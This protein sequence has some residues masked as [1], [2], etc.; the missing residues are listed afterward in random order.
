MEDGLVSEFNSKNTHLSYG[1]VDYERDVYLAIH[2]EKLKRF[3]DVKR[4]LNL[5]GA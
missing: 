4:N 1:S 2:H 5:A 3:F